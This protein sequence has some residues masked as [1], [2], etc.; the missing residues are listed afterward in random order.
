MVKT[1]PIERDNVVRL[2][3]RVLDNAGLIDGLMAGD[4]FAAEQFCDRYLERI[5]RWVW[6]LL[7]ADPDH[8]DVVQQVLYGVLSSLGRLRDRNALNAYVDSVTLRTV[9]KEIR[10]RR[11]RRGVF[12][13]AELP[14]DLTD[15]ASPLREAHIR[16]VYGI[17]DEMPAEERIIFV[18][19]HL[20]GYSLNAVASIAGYSLSTTKR[21]LRKAMGSFKRRASR[22]P[23]LLS[24]LEEFHHET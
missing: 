15:P 7:G 11:R 13:P 6:R 19:R 22:D 14:E 24:M 8:D 10:R 12:D 4:A 16:S 23:V 9:R 18:L 5:N 3:P 1:N 20:E 21:R 17:L 2:S